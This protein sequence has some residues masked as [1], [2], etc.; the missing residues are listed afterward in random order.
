M[1]TVR[2][3]GLRLRDVRYIVDLDM[4]TCSDVETGIVL[5]MRG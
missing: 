1:Q 2:Q 4:P 5:P 3:R